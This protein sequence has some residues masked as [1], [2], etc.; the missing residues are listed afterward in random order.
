MWQSGPSWLLKDFGEWPVNQSSLQNDLEIE[1][2]I[3]RFQLKSAKTKS[4]PCN[5]VMSS[6]SKCQ[7]I[8]KSE[9]LELNYISSLVD[10]EALCARRSNLDRVLLIIAFFLRVIFPSSLLKSPCNIDCSKTESAYKK[11]PPVT[12]SER[13]DAFNLLIY[14]A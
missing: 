11:I 14:L 10:V 13:D 9:S 5:K 6:K 7:I 2:E 12:S 1:S 3:E 8:S 4:W